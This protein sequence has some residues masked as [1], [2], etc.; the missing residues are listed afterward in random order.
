[1]LSSTDSSCLVK[2]NGDRT[3]L[4]GGRCHRPG[5]PVLP[6]GPFS[7]ETGG[8]SEPDRRDSSP[9]AGAPPP[10]PPGRRH[11]QSPSPSQRSPDKSTTIS[12]RT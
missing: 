3:D 10:P 12:T 1:M 5:G 9:G 6:I 11:R 7:S 4:R 8:S 2:A